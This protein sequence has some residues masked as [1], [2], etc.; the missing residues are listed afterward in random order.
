MVNDN[1]TNFNVY[2]SI[3]TT[4]NRVRKETITKVLFQPV[5]LNLMKL[6]VLN[7]KDITL[8]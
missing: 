4:K 3:C 5:R 2:K 7:R 8:S 1:T 6:F